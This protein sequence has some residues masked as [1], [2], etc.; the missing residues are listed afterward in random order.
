MTFTIQ[1]QGPSALGGSGGSLDYA[2]IPRSIAV[3]FDLYSNEGNGTDSTG[4]YTDGAQPMMLA[5]NLSST[6]IVLHSGHLMHAHLVYNGTNLTMTLTDRVTS[7]TATE[8]FPVNIT[9]LVRGNSAYVGF[10]AGTGGSTKTQNVLS[11]TYANST[12]TGTTSYISYPSMEFTGSG[13]SLG[14]CASVTGGLLELTDGGNDE[15]RSA[16][17]ATAV[18]VQSVTTDFHFQQLNATADGM[19]FAVQGSSAPIQGV[20]GE[21]SAI[22]IFLRASRSSLTSKITPVRAMT[23]LA[24]IRTAPC[25]QWERST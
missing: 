15:S 19:T 25:S 5:V 2:G 22:R 16:W 9:S 10:T 20:S 11:W 7:S 24:C 18:P 17:F 1:G 4:Q 21:D 12:T 8:V 23:P 14:Y 6:G 3:R 13:L